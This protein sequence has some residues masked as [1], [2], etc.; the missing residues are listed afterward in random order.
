MA[1]AR[2]ACV[3]GYGPGIG[4]SCARKFAR[5]GYAVG[6]ISRNAEKLAAAAAAIPNS[7]AFPAD[8]TDE[9][10]LEAALGEVE[11]ALGPV[12]VM[13][14]NAGS[15]F[16]KAY[17]E[18]DA[19]QLELCLKTN[20]VGLLTAA[21][22]VVPKMAARGSGSVVVT[23]ATA[24][25]RGKARTTAFAAAKAAQRSLT[26]SIAKKVMPSGVHVCYAIIDGA[27]GDGDTRIH[28]DAIAETYYHLTRQP[29]SCWT[30]EL[31]VRPHVETW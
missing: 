27:V 30:F 26:Q 14:Y 9:G 21:K 8:V 11:K 12:E 6:L 17:D 20:T 16:W 28:P 3:I 10:S 7:R 1:V 13:I 29:K 5:E 2:V 24:A 4:A 23:G 22:A 15:G 31:D 19:S 18:I 25:L